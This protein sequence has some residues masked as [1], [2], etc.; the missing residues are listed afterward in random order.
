MNAGRMENCLAVKA[1][2]FLKKREMFGF[3]LFFMYI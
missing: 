2:L 3:D 1:I